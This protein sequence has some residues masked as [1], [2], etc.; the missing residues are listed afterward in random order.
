MQTVTISSKGQLVI[1]KA[2]RD[3]VGLS[4][5]VQLTARV[6]DGEIRLR[7]LRQ[8]ASSPAQLDA[9]AGCLAKPKR[10]RLSDAATQVAIKARL[11]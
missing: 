10:V 8:D 9:V 6:V 1:P 2:M 3:V 7:P 5:G 11:K 4:F